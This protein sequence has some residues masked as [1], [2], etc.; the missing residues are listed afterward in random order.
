M[1]KV[2]LSVE[3]RKSDKLASHFIWEMKRQGIT[4]EEMA[5]E[6]GTSR[7]TFAK[8]LDSGG[9]TYIELLK[10][11]RKLQADVETIKS[12]MDFKE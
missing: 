1:P 3:E 10:I 11:F 4:Y 7:Q 12:L 8:K 6:L 5:D 9:F 2:R